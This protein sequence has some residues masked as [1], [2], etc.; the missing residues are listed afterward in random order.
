VS[1]QNVLISID[2]TEVYISFDRNLLNE[3]NSTKEKLMLIESLL[4]TL[5]DN[6]ITVQQVHLLVHHQE[7]LDSHLDFSHAWPIIGFLK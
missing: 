1:L 7:M 2:E 3:E 4:K 5:R 6:E